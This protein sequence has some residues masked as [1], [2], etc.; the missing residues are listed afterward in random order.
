MKDKAKNKKKEKPLGIAS[1]NFQIFAIAIIT[2]IVGYFFLAKGPADSQ[3]S[4]TVAPLILVL[5]Y[6][7]LVPLAIL[8]KPKSQKSSEKSK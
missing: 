7:I 8:Y 5:G 1:R 4:L 6:C 2:I 3:A